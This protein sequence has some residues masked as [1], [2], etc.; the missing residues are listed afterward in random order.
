[1]VMTFRISQL[2]LFIVRK[3]E[4]S[5][6]MLSGIWKQRVSVYDIY[7]YTHIHMIYIYMYYVNM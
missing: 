1:M 7:I 5:C 3:L 4:V 2:L 6:E